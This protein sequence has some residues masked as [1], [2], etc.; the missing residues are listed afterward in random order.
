MSK[1]QRDFIKDLQQTPES[2]ENISTPSAV[3]IRNES[4]ANQDIVKYPPILESN[5]KLFYRNVTEHLIQNP[6]IMAYFKDI[7]QKHPV[8][9]RQMDKDESLTS[10]PSDGFIYFIDLIKDLRDLI[11]LRFLSSMTEETGRRERIQLILAQLSILTKKLSKLQP[12]LL[13]IKSSSDTQSIERLNQIQELR[14]ILCK[15]FENNESS[16]LE[17][18]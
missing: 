17:E 10:F 7:V 5:L 6:N 15:Q 16:V 8:A 12:I 14:G 11:R 3:S 13:D 2:E 4:N 9:E 1:C 18:M